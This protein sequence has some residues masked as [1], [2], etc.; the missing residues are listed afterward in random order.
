MRRGEVWWG[1]APAPVGRRPFLIVSRDDLNEVR[2]RVVVAVVTAR[3][4]GLPTEV[5]LGADEGLPRE[6]VVNLGDL[7][8]IT[9]ADLFTLAGRIDA[10]KLRQVEDALRLVLALDDRPATPLPP[11]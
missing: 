4:R 1:E 10:A 7:A 3:I 8:V 2:G 11:R 9:K 5:A 6:C